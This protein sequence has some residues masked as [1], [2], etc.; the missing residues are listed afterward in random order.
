MAHV[1]LNRQH[2]KVDVTAVS[3]DGSPNYLILY[4][5]NVPER[6]IYDNNLSRDAFD[7]I[8][9]LIQEDFPPPLPVYFQI[10]GAYYLKHQVTGDEYLWTGSFHG[11]Y[12]SA[13]QLTPF[14]QFIGADN[15]SQFAFNMTRQPE[16]SFTW[17]GRDTA[18]TFDRLE[19]I[20]VNVQCEVSNRNDIFEK[21]H[22]MQLR[23]GRRRRN[24]KTF[25]VP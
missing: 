1:W 7:R 22:L 13:A 11:K 25:H 17:V 24:H 2:L 10:T 8:G 15:F 6:I 19:A 14:Y 21:R 4:N 3:L 23:H 5:C 9:R 18:W 12:S 16:V 20:I